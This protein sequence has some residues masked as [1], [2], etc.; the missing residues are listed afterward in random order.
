[1]NSFTFTDASSELVAAGQP[2]ALFSINLY[3]GTINKRVKT[4]YRTGLGSL[5]DLKFVSYHIGR[6]KQITTSLS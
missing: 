3:R 6:L 5:I 4:T 2:N 1:M